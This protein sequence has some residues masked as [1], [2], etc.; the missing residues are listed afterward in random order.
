MT[1]STNDGLMAIAAVRY[2]L[3][4]SSYITEAC[5]EWVRENWQA[6]TCNTRDVILRDVR[7]A[8]ERGEVGH[9]MDAREWERLVAWI[10]AQP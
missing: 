8:L 1:H 2:C 5:C 6:M 7:E 3:P 4:R 10:E 9:A